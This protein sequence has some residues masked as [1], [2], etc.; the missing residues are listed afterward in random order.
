MHFLAHCLIPGSDPVFNKRNYFQL[1]SFSIPLLLSPLL[2]FLRVLHKR[3]V[4]VLLFDLRLRHLPFLLLFL[5]KCLIQIPEMV[6]NDWNFFLLLLLDLLL[7]P[8][9]Y[10]LFLILLDSFLLFLYDLIALFT[11]ALVI[12]FQ[13]FLIM[14]Q[15]LVVPFV[16]ALIV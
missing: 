14:R 10:L 2:F 15:G 4:L 11:S 1:R 6:Y 3:L 7:F 8:C 12:P 5:T 13:E 9:N 16:E